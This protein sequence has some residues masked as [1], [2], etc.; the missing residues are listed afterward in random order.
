MQL[1]QSAHRLG[2]SCLKRKIGQ[3]KQFT[4]IPPGVEPLKIPKAKLQAIKS[5]L[6]GL[7]E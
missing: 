5:Q 6:D 3:P 2:K 4:N 1:S 7:H